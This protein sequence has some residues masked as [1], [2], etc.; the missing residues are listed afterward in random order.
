MTAEQ[1]IVWDRT[2]TLKREF[3]AGELHA[4]AGVADAHAIIALNIASAA[5]VHLR[6][7]PCRT[8]VAEVKL[9]VEAADCCF[10][11][12][13]MVTCT[14]A[15]AADR[16]IKRDAI[17]VVEVLSPSTAAYIRGDKF[18]AYRLLPSLRE[19]LLVDPRRRRCDLSQPPPTRQNKTSTVKPCRNPRPPAFPPQTH[20]PAPS[21]PSRCGPAL[22]CGRQSA[23]RG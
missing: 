19:Y 13:I 20:R 10:Y 11:P 7:T 16:L 22:H 2:Q 21:L 15:D 4:M 23:P 8:F 5:K 9:R 6:G 12:D 1:F 3:S 17:L 18:A 14:A